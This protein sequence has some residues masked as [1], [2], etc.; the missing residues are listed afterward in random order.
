MRA[1]TS[2]RTPGSGG[3]CPGASPS[4]NRELVGISH[5]Q[6][7]SIA[8]IRDSES[9]GDLERRPVADSPR[10]YGR[11]E[12]AR[13]GER[14]FLGAAE[15]AVGFDTGHKVFSTPATRGSAGKAAEC[16]RYTHAVAE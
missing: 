1:E 11:N 10:E 14:G 2:E 9:R 7:I 13:L 16:S 5:T 15:P 3:T 6:Q 8:R 12:M 4:S